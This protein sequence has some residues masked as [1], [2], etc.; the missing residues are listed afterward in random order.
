MLNSLN[1]E[2]YVYTSGKHGWAVKLLTVPDSAPTDFA[3]NN[4]VV[5]FFIPGSAGKIGSAVKIKI[6]N[7]GFPDVEGV[8]CLSDALNRWASMERI[9]AFFRWYALAE[10][11]SSLFML[12]NDWALRIGPQSLTYILSWWTRCSKVHC[13]CGF[14]RM[15]SDD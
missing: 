2:I 10:S 14:C 7:T 15:L 12:P 5:R 6:K 4:H 13:R 9:W 11:R 1:F 8:Q 3:L